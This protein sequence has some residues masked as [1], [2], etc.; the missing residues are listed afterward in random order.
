MSLKENPEGIFAFQWHITDN[1][2]QRC[3]HCYI[4]AEDNKKSLVS[5]D[6][7]QMREVICKCEEFTAKLDMKPT[8][9]I[10]G[11]DPLLAPDF[12]KLAELLREKGY[13]Y[14]L[15][16]NPFHLNEEVCRRLKESG[17]VAYQLSLDGMEDTHD[18]IRKP[19]S[20]KKTMD[21]IPL[22]LHARIQSIVMMTVSEDN[23]KELGAVMDA[24][25]K[26][27]ADIFSIA[28]YVPTS[29]DKTLGIPPL[30]YRK[31]LKVFADKRKEAIKRGSF[32]RFTIKD[33]LLTL[34]YYEE[35]QFKLPEYEHK[36]GDHMPAGCHCGN[37]MLTILPDGTVMGC[38][39]AEDT[40]LGIPSSLRHSLPEY[41]PTCRRA[42]F[43]R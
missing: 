27:G 4:F 6:I 17:C 14:V 40:V 28:R 33:H 13:T 9:A 32:T 36:A 18:R 42:C 10:T 16:G 22:L 29:E 20:F 8:F 35:G 15:M 12:W 24:A 3:S 7:A 2:D 19:G 26:A 21:T 37:A 5:M 31:V 39:R 38:R 25:E 11:G 23:F 43:L 30:E 34:Y 1:C 41:R